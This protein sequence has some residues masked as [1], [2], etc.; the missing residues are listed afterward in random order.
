MMK[1]AVAG[2]TG[3]TGI[4]LVTELRKTVASVRAIARST[5]RLAR[6]F[7]D[8][9]VEKWL[10]DILDAD[11]TLRAIEGC[12]LVYDCIGLPGDQMHLHPVT[13]RNIAEALR[14]TKAR[15]VQVS[16]YWAYY[17]QVRSEMNENHP[18]SGGPPWVR[19]RREAEDVLGA[20]GAAILHL[21]DFYGPRVHVSTL[22]NALN[23]A[24]SGKTVNWLGRADIQ[25]EYVY[26]PDAMRI[27]VEIGA[28][29][30]ALGEHWCLPGSGPLSGRQA[31]DI[32]ARHLG[33]QVKMRAA[34]M[35]TL[36]IVSIFNKD[37]RGLL[38]VAPNYM[39]PVRYDTRKL[40][41]LLGPQQMTSYDVG[42]DRTLA[43]IA[44]R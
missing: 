15:C 19:Y 24:A 8:A 30:E 43:W 11:A 1:I 12:D 22:Q 39:K 29:N 18:R 23:E 27:A 34:G 37:L 41:G 31:A 33:R 20:A 32:A 3:P 21:P 16:S 14:H 6:L 10:A 9:A 44:S 42:V 13:A 4:H 28:R 17:P 38:Q 2:A 5:D 40:Q 26:V 35:T 36:R 25:R 7:P